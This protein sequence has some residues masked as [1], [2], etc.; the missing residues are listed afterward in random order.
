MTA[1]ATSEPFQVVVTN[2]EEHEDGAA[3]YSFEMDDK[4]QEEIANIGLE[5]MLYC[6]SYGLDLQYVLEN[7]DL[8]AEHQNN[9]GTDSGK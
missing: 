1:H 8:I 9:V 5:F 2:V 7:L 6:A 3:T 4:A